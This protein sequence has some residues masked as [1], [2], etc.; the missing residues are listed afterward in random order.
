MFYLDCTCIFSGTFRIAETTS[1]GG[2]DDKP[3]DQG[4]TGAVDKALNGKNSKGGGEA[5]QKGA[6]STTPAT[7]AHAQGFARA[8][9]RT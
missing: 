5:G 9:I 2:A 8:L 7:G 3:G 1:G 4:L 6:G